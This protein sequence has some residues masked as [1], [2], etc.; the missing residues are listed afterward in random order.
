MRHSM[1]ESPSPRLAPLATLV[2][3]A[4]LSTLAGCGGGNRVRVE[5][6]AIPFT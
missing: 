4:L 5:T 3:L 2:T 1:R 6:P